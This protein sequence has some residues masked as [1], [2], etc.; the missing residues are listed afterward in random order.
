MEISTVIMFLE[1][2]NDIRSRP[3]S[4]YDL[5]TLYIC[6]LTLYTLTTVIITYRS[7]SYKNPSSGKRPTDPFGKRDSLG[8]CVGREML[9][10]DT[11]PV[12]L[13]YKNPSSG[14][15]STQNHI[16]PQNRFLWN[17]LFENIGREGWNLG[18]PS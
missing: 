5:K 15:M 8:N 3:N 6:D 10:V 7:L 18:R 14:K 11:F 9:K 2:Q 17:G 4:R 12:L 1:F 13:S 16:F